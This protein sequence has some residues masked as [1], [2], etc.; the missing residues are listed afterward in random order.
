MLFLYISLSFL[1]HFFRF[2]LVTCSWIFNLKQVYYFFTL[3]PSYAVYTVVI[4]LEHSS[5]L[6]YETISND[7]LKL[8]SYTKFLKLWSVK[9]FC[10]NIFLKCLYFLLREMYSFTQ[11]WQLNMNF[12]IYYCLL[13]VFWKNFW[14]CKWKDGLLVKLKSLDAPLIHKQSD[15][16]D[17]SE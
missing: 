3:K 16:W 14:K 7:P 15:I 17:I 11:N 13:C 6:P 2:L 8:T 10:F 12:I 4:N 5:I 1:F 9:R